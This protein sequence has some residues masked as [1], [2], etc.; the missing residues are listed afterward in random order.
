MTTVGRFDQFVEDGD[1]DFESYVERFEHFLKA[2]K[3]S[4]DLKVSTFITAIGKK[5]LQDPE[6]FARAGKA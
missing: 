4:D 3:V 2:S 5:R 1:E 6:N